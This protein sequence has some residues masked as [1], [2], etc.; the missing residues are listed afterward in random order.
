MGSGEIYEELTLIYN[1]VRGSHLASIG[2]GGS[3]QIQRRC[4]VNAELG[5]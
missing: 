4:L 3:C 5:A 2:P 1:S